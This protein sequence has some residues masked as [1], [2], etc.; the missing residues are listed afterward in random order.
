MAFDAVVDKTRLEKAMKATADAIRS[1]TELDELIQWNPDRGFADE[2]NKLSMQELIRHVDIPDYVKA[3]AIRVAN[4]VQSTREDDSIVFIAMS[5]NHHYGEQADAVQYPDQNGIQ[6]DV[7]NLHAAMAAKILAYGLN[8][9]FMAQ[10]GDV[11]FGNAQT[12][13]ALLQSQANELVGFLREA[14]EDIPCFH[15]IG[16][17]DTGIYYH[18]QMVAD[19]KSGVFTESG[20][21]LYK[22]FTLLS[23]SDNTVFGGAANGG[24]CYRDFPDKKL[25]VF[26]LNTSEALTVN[27]SDKATLGSQ[28]KWFADALINLNT[29]S[30]AAS[31]RFI[32]LSHYPADY[33]NTM[34]LSELLRAYVEGKSISIS[35]ESG[36]TAT[37]NF[38]S[39]NK[40]KI[41]A[42]F[43]GHVHNFITSRLS[44]YEGGKGVKYEAWRVCVP[45]GQFNRENY[46]TTV[47]SYTDIFFGEETTATKTKNTAKDTSFVV[48]VINPSTET[49]HSICYGA[50]RDRLISYG[51][52]TYFSIQSTLSNVT[53]SNTDSSIAE[54]MP[55]VA[56]LIPADHS[57]LKS[58]KVKM[59]GV[60]ITSSAYANNTID[61]PNVT[62]NIVIE[63]AAEIAYACTNWIPLSTDDTG[64]IYNGIG[65]KAK[66]YIHA[67]NGADSSNSATSAIGY[68]PI[69]V[70]DVIRIRGMNFSNLE[71]NH[72]LGFYTSDKTFISIVQANSKWYMETKFNGVLE[73]DNYVEFTITSIEG[74]TDTA[75]YMRICGAGISEASIVTVNEEIKYLDELE[76]SYGISYNLSHATSSN[77]AASVAGGARYT[78]TL[79][80]DANYRLTVVTVTMDGKDI[81]SNVYSNGVITIPTVTG[82]VVITAATESTIKYTNQIPIST[83]ANGAVYNGT[84]FKSGYRLSSSGAESSQAGSCVTG[85]IPIK[86]NDIVRM[87]N[88]QYEKVASTT[89]TPNNQR[90]CFYD[91][92]KNFLGL[93]IASSA[94]VQ[95]RVYDGDILTQFTVK[96]TGDC[97]VTNAKY[98]RINAVYIGADSIITVNEAI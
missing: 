95:N 47:G 30:D 23:D 31:W 82:N 7:S 3:E 98:F 91:A 53:L 36:S 45:N 62:G 20:E 78:T 96:S 52:S 27:Q 86:A 33:G 2:V 51:A 50:G 76:N 81:T 8:I 22:K 87:R 73:G 28:R 6:T 16:N 49:I 11:T 89:L 60:D 74:V 39:K 35:L 68:I 93:V 38:A 90:V 56:T 48:N 46:Y 84:G 42:Q 25:R 14:H 9:D 65:Y 70:G 15:A 97:D 18:Q 17:H 59:G 57:I 69:K 80:A 88:I 71:G 26:L 5:D 94:T 66:V 21:W 44:V 64:S 41:I 54:G 79:S 58:V 37:V 10:L 1:K 75:A 77:M 19:G 24:Y 12:T 55:F 72:R 43:H 32:V 83:D 61:I 92:D 34:P 63:A 85:F 29:K 4:L 13:S 67:S 40:A